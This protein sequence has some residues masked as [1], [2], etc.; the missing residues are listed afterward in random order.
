MICY[1]LG[2]E[3]SWKLKRGQLIE[4]KLTRNSKL[5]VLESPLTFTCRNS[6]LNAPFQGREVPNFKINLKPQ[7]VDNHC[8]PEP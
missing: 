3:N 2:F 4:A 5:P 7:D 1:L 8:S 6:K